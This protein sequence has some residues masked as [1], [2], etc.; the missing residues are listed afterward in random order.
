M[1]A[2]ILNRRE[3]I[4]FYRALDAH[5]ALITPQVAILAPAAHKY[6]DDRSLSSFV[7]PVCRVPIADQ[8]NFHFSHVQKSKILRSLDI[9]LISI[10][11]SL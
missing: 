7:Q 6:I 10:L 1:Q 9:I 3:E 8:R 5:A 2:L 4:P 11:H